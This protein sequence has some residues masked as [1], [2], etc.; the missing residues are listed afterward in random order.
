M[1]QGQG[2]DDALVETTPSLA[3]AYGS[4]LVAEEFGLIFDSEDLRFSGI[5]AVVAAG[6]MVG[7]IGL[8]NTSPTTRITLEYF[9]A[10][11]TLSCIHISY[12]TI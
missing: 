6:L 5:L 1:Y 12:L 4:F 2:V 10:V 3:L 11:L 8:R 9:W 7:N